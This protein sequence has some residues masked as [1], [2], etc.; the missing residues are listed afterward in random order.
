PVPVDAWVQLEVLLVKASDPSGRI[1]VWQNG[2]LIFDHPGATV[3]NDWIQWDAG[4]ASDD[5]TPSP[6]TVY[7]DDASI[8]TAFLDL[9]S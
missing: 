5:L 7:L 4:G 3:Q 9:G 2:A 1:A 6:A 8:S